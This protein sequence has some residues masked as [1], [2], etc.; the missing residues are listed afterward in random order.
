[1]SITSPNLIQLT[2]KEAF[3]ELQAVPLQASFSS[4]IIRNRLGY[5]C[6][7]CRERAGGRKRTLSKRLALFLGMV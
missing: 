6:A 4:K 1:M 7:I 2:L 5:F 3:A